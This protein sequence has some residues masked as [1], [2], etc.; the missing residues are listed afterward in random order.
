MADLSDLVHGSK[1]QPATIL[2]LRQIQQGDR[3]GLPIIVGIFGH[4]AVDTLVVLFGE[5]K[6]SLCI[7]FFGIQVLQSEQ[8]STRNRNRIK[9]AKG[10]EKRMFQRN[11]RWTEIGEK[12]YKGLRCGHASQGLLLK[13]VGDGHGRSRCRRGKHFI[14][15]KRCD[16]CCNATTELK[17]F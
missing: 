11:G 2:T 1:W 15:L 12:T 13:A 4:N 17:W 5:I 8:K 10:D 16:Y 14:F 7:V 9:R 3:A 6:V